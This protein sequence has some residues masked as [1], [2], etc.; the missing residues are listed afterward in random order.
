VIFK[1]AIH[2]S[3]KIRIEQKKTMTYDVE[4]PGFG[5]EQVQIICFCFFLW[6]LYALSTICQLY[7]GGQICWW[8]KPEEPEK[9][10]DLSQVSDQ[11][12]HIMLYTSP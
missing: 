6:C 3:Q 11:L 2:I 1:N 8:R 9:T 10:T 12:Y 5:L 7:R 4:N